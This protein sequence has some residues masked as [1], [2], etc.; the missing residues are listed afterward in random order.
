MGYTITDLVN[1][2]YE[3]AKAHGFWEDGESVPA[4][5][6]ISTKLA[7][8]HS[9]VS[10]ALEEVRVLDKLTETRY[11]GDKPEGFPSELADAVIRI[12]DICGRLGIDLESVIVEKQAFNRTRPYRHGR[13]L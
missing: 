11:N 2:S 10:E 12:A 6:V 1:E 7:L 3:I 8:V 9:E 13:K 4:K 5:Y